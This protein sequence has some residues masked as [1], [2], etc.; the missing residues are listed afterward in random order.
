VKGLLI[1]DIKA[2]KS[3]FVACVVSEDHGFRRVEFTLA[4]LYLE[5][6]NVFSDY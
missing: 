6:T 1:I 4:A 5:K 3:A 2:L